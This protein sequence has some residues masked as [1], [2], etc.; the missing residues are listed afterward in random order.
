MEKKQI[1]KTLYDCAKIKATEEGLQIE[2]MFDKE[3]DAILELFIPHPIRQQ[4]L[5]ELEALYAESKITHS[6]MVEILNEIAAGQHKNGI[7]I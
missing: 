5:I 2:R 3:A 4:H 1:I 7:E 6:R